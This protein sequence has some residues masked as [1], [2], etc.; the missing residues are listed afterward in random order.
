M[1]DTSL[2]SGHLLLVKSGGIFR[3]GK[4][5]LHLAPFPLTRS[6]LRPALLPPLRPPLRLTPFANISN[7]LQEIR[8]SL[9]LVH[10]QETD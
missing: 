2:N 8:T 3:L 4:P 10:N 6:T 5:L 1:T 9:L 7:K